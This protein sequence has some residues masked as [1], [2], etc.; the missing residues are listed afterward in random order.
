M[1]WWSGVAGPSRRYGPAA[2]VTRVRPALNFTVKAQMSLRNAFGA[3]GA[4]LPALALLS[5]CAGTSSNALPKHYPPPTG[6]PAA[7]IDVGTRAQ[8]WSVDGAET[9]SLAKTLRL[10]P[11][12]HRVGI[13]CLSWEVVGH[14]P[15]E[16]VFFPTVTAQFVLVTGPFEAGRTYYARC[17][18]VDGQPRAWL[19]D[20]RD[21]ND[22]PRGFTSICTR[23][24]PR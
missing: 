18:S 10:A 17:V 7:V 12:E 14:P 5:G 16:P 4:G 19:A 1:R 15:A 22:L 21:G 24:C 11:G 2:P 6:A 9:P 8:A 23:R 20:A 13:N 3:V